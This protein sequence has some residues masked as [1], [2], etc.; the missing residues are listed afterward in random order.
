VPHANVRAHRPKASTGYP[1]ANN[2]PSDFLLVPR[3]FRRVERLNIQDLM[4]IT[5]SVRI[6]VLLVLALGLALRVAHAEIEK[7]AIPAAKGKSFHWWPKLRPLKGWRHDHDESLHYG[8]N[9]L[10][11]DGS[12]FADAET[13]MYAK[14]V[15]K[16]QRPESKTLERFIESDKK[17]SLSR[18]PDIVIQEGA[19]LSTADGRKLRSFTF[20]PRRSGNWER[21]SYGEEGDFYLVFAV[22]SRSLADYKAAEKAYVQLIRSYKE[23]P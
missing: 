8:I 6:A 9:A 22:S 17:A 3:F 15:Y 1:I 16:P 10:V 21:V 20:F 7:V 12:T 5:A 14:A 4:K 13:V 23:K 2:N 18:S 19:A 11:P